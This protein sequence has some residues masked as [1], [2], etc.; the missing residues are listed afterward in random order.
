[1]WKDV[2]GQASTEVQVAMVT[3]LVAPPGSVLFDSVTKT[4]T[5]QSLLTKASAKN[6]ITERICCLYNLHT[7]K[8]IKAV[9]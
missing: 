7:M 9:C 6:L 5:V 2:I 3:A 1:M 8:F 4:R